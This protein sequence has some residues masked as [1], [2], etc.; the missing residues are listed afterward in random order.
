MNVL[1][2]L[3]LITALSIPTTTLVLRSGERIDVDGAVRQEDGRILFRSGGALYS[4]PADEVDLEATREA[5]SAASVTAQP[6]A[7]RLKVSPEERQRL[8]RE[9]EQNHSGKPAPANALDIPPGPTPMERERTVQ[10][11]WSWRR[12]AR[13]YEEGIRRAQE[14]FDLLVFRAAALKA[15]IAGL[16]SLGFKPDQFSYDTTQLAYTLEQIPR[17]ELEAQRAARAYDQFRDEARRLGVTPGW[18]R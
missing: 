2:H 17:A 5:A 15:H 14:E 18:L 6:P 7:G 16:L 10:D 8:L 9:L 1:T 3:L 4:L 12:Q 11:E 13:A